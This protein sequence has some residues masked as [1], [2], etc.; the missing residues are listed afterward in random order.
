[1]RHKIG[2]V[3]ENLR[4]VGRRRGR[5]CEKDGFTG[6]LRKSRRLFGAITAILNGY[7]AAVLRLNQTRFF[8][9]QNLRLCGDN[10]EYIND[11]RS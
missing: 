1:M 2:E 7:R 5:F 4:K 3:L 10:A 8:A 9:W 6:N 11:F